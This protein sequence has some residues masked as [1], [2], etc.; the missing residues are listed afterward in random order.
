MIVAFDVKYD[1]KILVNEKKI[2]AF[3]LNHQKLKFESED[4]N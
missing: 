4:C 1:F 3:W 2:D